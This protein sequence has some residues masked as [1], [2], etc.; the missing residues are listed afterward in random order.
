MVP[1]KLLLAARH[2]SMLDNA[3]SGVVKSFWVVPTVGCMQALRG[4]PASVLAILAIA[5]LC[6]GPLLVASTSEQ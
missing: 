6:F 3:T 5:R 2:R 1:A 4:M